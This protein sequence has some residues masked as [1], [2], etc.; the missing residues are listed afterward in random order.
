MPPRRLADPPRAPR[1]L[2]RGLAS[3]LLDCGDGVRLQA[4]HSPP[5]AAAHAAR[6]A[7]ARLGRQRRIDL[8]AVGWRHCC[9]QHGFGVVRLNLRDHGAT[10]APQP[11]IVSFLPAARSRRRRDGAERGSFR[12]RALYLGGF[13]L[14]GNFMLRVAADG[15]VP[16]SVAGVVAVSPVLD[17]EA[18]LRALEQ[19]LP[20]YRRY[21]VR[22]WSR[23]LRRKQRAWPGVHD[24]EAHVRLRRICAA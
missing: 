13:S 1:H 4:F 5:P 7:A 15:G 22:R 2:L 16:T 3:L 10:H 19:A 17:P 21:F 18:T 9:S 11:R 23:S 14:G 20:V 24:F 12:G 8:R 6:G